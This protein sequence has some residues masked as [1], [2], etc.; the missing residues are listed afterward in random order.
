MAILIY[1]WLD[2][3]EPYVHTHTRVHFPGIDSTPQLC[4]MTTGGTAR[5]VLFLQLSVSL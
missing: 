2:C 1:M 4:K 5:N 3:I